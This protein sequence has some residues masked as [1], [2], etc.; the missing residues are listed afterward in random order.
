MM[1]PTIIARAVELARS[2]EYDRLS[3]IAKQLTR[4]G[5]D[6]ANQHLDAGSVRRLIRA[7]IVKGRHQKDVA[8]PQST[9]ASTTRSSDSSAAE[10]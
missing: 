8:R 4:E 5:Y 3:Y 2:G 7:E 1:K 6:L 9:S 10:A